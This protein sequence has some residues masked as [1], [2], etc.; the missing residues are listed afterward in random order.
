MVWSGL[1][2]WYNVIVT[3]KNVSE[4]KAELSALL[5]MVENGEEVIIARS[6][7]PVAKLSAYTPRREPR[8]PGAMRGEIIV[9]DDFDDLGPELESLFFGGKD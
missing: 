7:R 2:L 9:P 6:G 3:I 5:V 1:V 8:V 4:A